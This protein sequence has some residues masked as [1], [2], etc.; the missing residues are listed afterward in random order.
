MTD[1]P[2]LGP[3]L[4][5]AGMSNAPTVGG[6]VTLLVAFP[7]VLGYKL[8]HLDANALPFKND[9]VTSSVLQVADTAD[10]LSYAT[11]AADVVLGVDGHDRGV[12]MV[13]QRRTSRRRTVRL[14]RHRRP[15][16]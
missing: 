14:G 5:A 7:T 6:L 16:R 9:E 13:C 15:R 8:A 12:A 4:K 2:V 3:L 10:D 11:F 1:L